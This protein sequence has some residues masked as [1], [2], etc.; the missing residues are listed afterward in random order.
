MNKIITSSIVALSLGMI[1][2]A[3]AASFH[4]VDY[5]D[6]VRASFNVNHETIT[7]SVLNKD[8]VPDVSRV[9]TVVDHGIRKIPVESFQ[10]N[11]TAVSRHCQIAQTLSGLE[12]S[13]CIYK[14]VPV[15][16]PSPS[17]SNAL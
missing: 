3:Q 4:S 9:Q 7:A 8:I 10:A 2:P 17:T 6:Q 5:F 11:M 1:A 15:V 16:Y 12:V 13:G 14:A